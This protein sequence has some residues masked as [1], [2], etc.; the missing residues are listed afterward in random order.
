MNKKP[1]LRKELEKM[2]W[3]PI[4][5]IEKKLIVRSLL[6]GV[7]LIGLLLWVSNAFFQP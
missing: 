5:P 2:Q 7:G 1:D 4:L 6:V 3:E